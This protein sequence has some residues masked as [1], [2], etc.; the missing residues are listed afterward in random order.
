MSEGATEHLAK[1]KRLL[2]QAGSLD[3][4]QAPEAVI[5]LAYYAMYHAA[6]AVLLEGA[7]QPALTH[8]GLIGAFGKLMRERGEQAR[9]QGRLL[10]RAENLR[11]ASDYG[12]AHVD[13]PHGA[14]ELLRD[15][16]A[17]VSFC[18]QARAE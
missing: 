10:N 7:G 5:H 13:L 17:F 4:E 1:A 14:A 15:A 12:V 2:G 3:P 6:T 9:A 18:Q 16:M 11:L 8:G